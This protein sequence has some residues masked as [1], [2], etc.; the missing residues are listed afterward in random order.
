MVVVVLITVLV[1]VLVVLN[2]ISLYSPCLP[3]TWSPYFSLPHA[4]IKEV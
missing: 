3:K 1:L 4:G 2:G